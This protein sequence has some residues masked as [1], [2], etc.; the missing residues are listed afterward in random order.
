MTAP[1]TSRGFTLIEVVITIAIVGLLAGIA[2]PTLELVMQRNREQE[3]RL[4]LREIRTALDAYK[5]AYDSGRMVRLVGSSGYPPTLRILAEGVPDAQDPNK[6]KIFF[7]RRVPR[8]PM[9]L[10][11]GLAPE[12]TWGLRSYQ[13]EPDDPQAGEDVYDVYSLAQGNGLNGVP[14]RQW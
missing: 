2:V 3:L 7:L 5:Q 10:D 4:A 14:Y 11:P 6:R 13:S 12:Q 9:S 1:A 8:D